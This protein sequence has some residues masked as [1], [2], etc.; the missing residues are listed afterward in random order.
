[1]TRRRKP[2]E[3]TLRDRAAASAADRFKALRKEVADDLGIDPDSDLAEH[4]AVLRLMRDAILARLLRSDM[5]RTDPDDLL[6]ID[7]AL[8]QHQ[9]AHEPLQINVRF[10]EAVSGTFRCA[11]CGEQNTL[12]SGTYT[13]ARPPKRETELDVSE[14][15]DSDPDKPA[16]AAA[17]P[18][19]EATSPNGVTYREGVNASAFHSAVLRNDEIPPLKKE[20]PAIGAHVSP[21][22]TVAGLWCNDP[23]PTRNGALA[24][25]LP[26]V[27]GKG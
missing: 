26:A 16:E 21:S 12:A 22:D 14:P 25:R 27:N 10:V 9:P 1:M 20:Q 15:S 19:P 6:K 24:Q 8:K 13:A 5:L 4:V 11:C 7:A 17:A 23:N 3:A 2:A 18:E